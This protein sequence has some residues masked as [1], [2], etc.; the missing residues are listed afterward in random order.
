MGWPGPIDYN[1][2]FQH[3]E[4]VLAAPDLRA[5]RVATNRRGLPAVRAGGFALVYK[6][7]RGPSA[8]A[9]RVFLYPSDEREERYRVVHGHLAR[10]LPRC[11]VDFGYQPRGIRIGRDSYPLQTMRWVEGEP[12]NAWVHGVVSRG[13]V[14]RLR[15]L[16]ACW[17]ELIGELRRAGIAHGDLQHGNVLVM[18]DDRSVLVDYDGMCVP[19]LVGRPALE[20]GLPAYQHPGRRQQPLSLSLDD[21]SAWIILIALRALA[22]EPALWKRFV[23]DPDNENLLFTE[24]DITRPRASRLW[25]SLASSPD[26]EVRAWAET[27]HN[28]LEQP[29]EQV[30]PFTP[31]DP[32]RRRPVSAPADAARVLGSSPLDRLRRI[33]SAATLANDRAFVELWR[34]IGQPPTSDP[35]VAMWKTRY[36]ERLSRLRRFES[37]IEVIRQVDE[38]NAS[39]QAILRA[40]TVLPDGYDA[41]LASR[42]ARARARA[43]NVN[44]SRSDDRADDRLGRLVQAIEAGD[45]AAFLSQVDLETLH[46]HL[47]RLRPFRRRIEGWV[48]THVLSDRPLRMTLEPPSIRGSSLAI[49]ATWAKPHLVSHLSVVVYDADRQ[50]AGESEVPGAGERLTFDRFR[51]EGGI[52]VTVPPGVRRPTVVVWPVVDLGWTEILGA[53]VRLGPFRVEPTGPGSSP[54]SAIHRH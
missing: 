32:P 30:P 11:L 15:K 51:R 28:C 41:M 10:T 1:E 38:G 53:P 17:V 39:E 36:E 12:L 16:A 48:R 31:N 8:T 18:P 5:C 50:T 43:R 46:G 44:S 7:E 27:L 52:V 45:H 14:A 19:G 4:R 6:L 40:A 26:R 23:V 33:P 20:V 34:S 35:A 29:F 9:A 49:R 3:P 25:K 13:E 21:F 37:L 22:A 47:D 2:A 54:G 42:V 24:T